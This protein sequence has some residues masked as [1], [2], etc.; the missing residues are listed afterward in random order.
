M[1]RG[2]YNHMP[3]NG[4]NI[5][6]THTVEEFISRKFEDELTYRNLSIVDYADGIELIDRSLISEYLP[7]LEG[8]CISYTF[9]T[10][11]YRRYKYSP[12]LLSYDLYKTT[13]LDFLLM[14]LNDMI[15]PKDFNLKRLKLPTSTILKTMLNEIYSVNAGW[16]SKNRYDLEKE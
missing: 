8:A 3:I 5:A 1:K 11:E 16:I 9:S 4:K 13:Q 15:D 6:Q 7:L 10:A 2:E 12:D 14:M